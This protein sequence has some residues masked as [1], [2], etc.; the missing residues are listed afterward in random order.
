MVG[1]ATIA[2]VLQAGRVPASS[3]AD[4]PDGMQVC[5][6]CELDRWY[7]RT[8]MD[9]KEMTPEDLEFTGPGYQTYSVHA[10]LEPLP[11]S[12]FAD[13]A[14]MENRPRPT[15]QDGWM[16]EENPLRHPWHRSLPWPELE[17][18]LRSS[19]NGRAPAVG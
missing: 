9:G 2:G 8:M 17:K 13:G 6:I 19:G 7:I 18:M 4:V 14:F 15:A 3:L 5:Y 12:S 1:Q 11:G 10:W 16:L